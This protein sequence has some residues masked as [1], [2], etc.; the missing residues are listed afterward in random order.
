MGENTPVFSALSP[1]RKDDIS[2]GFLF[3]RGK[4]N[5]IFE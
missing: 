4:T 2:P 1:V 5:G 3:F